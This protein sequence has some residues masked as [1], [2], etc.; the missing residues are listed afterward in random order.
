MLAFQR[1]RSKSAPVIV[2][3]DA[4]CINQGNIEERNQQVQT[5][6]RIYQQAIEVAIWLG[7]EA[8]NSNMALELLVEL[9]RHKSSKTNILAIIQSP[10]RRDSFTALVA[11][12]DRE[13]WGRL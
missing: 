9:Y 10:D 8:D 6:T 12:F 13:Y 3:A 2:W 4:I 5:M 7:P 11:L 1:L